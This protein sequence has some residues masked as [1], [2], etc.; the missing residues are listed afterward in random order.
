MKVSVEFEDGHRVVN[1]GV[2]MS[3]A[4]FVAMVYPEGSNLEYC[5]LNIQTRNVLIRATKREAGIIQ[6]RFV[7]LRSRVTDVSHYGDE[8]G[9]Q[10][11][12]FTWF[13]SDAH[14]I[15]LNM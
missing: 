2:N 6:M 11:Y 5:M 8:L 1:L 13:G 4:N 15:L 3:W 7:N 10:D 12:G 9:K 14:F